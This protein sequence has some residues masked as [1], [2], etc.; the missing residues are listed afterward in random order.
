MKKLFIMF[1]II[2]TS[3]VALGMP[4]V[5]PAPGLIDER[6]LEYTLAVNRASRIA[7]HYC[8]LNF[9]KANAF[10]VLT[11]ED[12]SKEELAKACKKSILLMRNATQAF[13]AAAE[14]L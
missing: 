11:S 3:I 10:E 8:K 7:N 9:G 12:L 4:N 6:I 5:D 1:S 14:Y 2:S 13:D